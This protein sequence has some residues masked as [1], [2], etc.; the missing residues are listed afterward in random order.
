[1]LLG[2]FI[3]HALYITTTVLFKTTDKRIA[4]AAAASLMATLG[5]L[6]HMSVDLPLVLPAI[7]SY[8]VLLLAIGYGAFSIEKQKAIQAQ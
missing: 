4:G 2:V 7:S 6:M 3:V 1:M 5:M 8:F